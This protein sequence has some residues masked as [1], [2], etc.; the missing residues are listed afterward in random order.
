MMTRLRKIIGSLAG[1]RY[2]Y[3]CPVCNRRVASFL[4][5]PD[6]YREKLRE[7]GCTYSL[8]DAETLNIRQYSCP[9][10]NSSDRERLY[11]LYIRERVASCHDKRLLDMVEFAPVPA[12]GNMIR[13][14][15]TFR[16][17]TADLFMDNVDDKVDLGNM[18]MYPDASFDC[19]ICSHVLEHVADDRKALRELQRILKPSGWGILMVPV[20]LHLNDIEEDPLVADAGER[21]RR[22]GQH[23]HLRMYS[24]KGFI[25]RAEEAGFS[26]D[27]YGWQHFGMC[28]FA[29]AGISEKSILYVVHK[30]A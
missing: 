18:S 10:C 11:A 28:L 4:P 30:S 15:G 19:F 21:W 20:M 12:L 3:C 16:L 23:D 1:P 22:F 9:Y 27:Q 7:H 17:R 29:K 2:F 5:L 14:T 24:K 26:V 25:H 13:N 6:F 8:D